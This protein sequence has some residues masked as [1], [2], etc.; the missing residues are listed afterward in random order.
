[1][2]RRQ[3][4]ITSTAALATNQVF[5]A[6]QKQ[7]KIGVIGHTGRGNFGHGLDYIWNSIPNCKIV[8]VADASLKG[9]V[10]AQERLKC[11]KSFSD[12][13][14]MLK[15][16][17][18]DIVA[19][20]T[21]HPDQHFEMMK[22]AIQNGARGIYIEKPFCRTPEEA[23]QILKL[24]KKKN[25][26]IA[27]AHRNRY[28]PVL[29][30]VKDLIKTGS[31]GKVL[32]IRGY[33]KND[34]RGGCED[35]WVL[36]S[37]VLNLA[38]YFAGTPTSCSASIRQDGK[39]PELTEVRE[40]P[41]AL[42]P[43]IGNE[44]HTRFETKSGI[45]IFFESVANKKEDSFN[46]GLRIIG[47]KGAF[48]IQCDRNPLV[49]LFDSK[50]ETTQVVSTNGIGKV[51]PNS[52]L[53]KKVFSHEVAVLDLISAIENNEEPICNVVEGVLTTE[54]SC[55]VLASFKEKKSVSLPLVKRT[56]P[57]L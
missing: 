41:E 50:T 21:R 42:G 56:H 44:V 7:Y 5:A 27:V 31:I 22:A 29:K 17:L 26:K 24:S 3:L 2:D 9:L 49:H 39:V 12:Y 4:L 34:H 14:K 6:A 13:K 15:E 57:F 55:A 11:S 45:P 30:T 1:M 28:H 46:F 38:C 8:S 43:I 10:K 52:L 53:H 47:D 18:P 48:I 51:E 35:L 54:L 33:G 19:I 25:C 16:S 37:H 36:G 32:E 20:C 40:G 23:D